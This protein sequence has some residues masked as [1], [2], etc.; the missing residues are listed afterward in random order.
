MSILADQMA[1]A[2]AADPGAFRTPC[3][4]YNPDIIASAHAELRQAI[5]TPLIVSLKANPNVDLIMR[6]KRVIDEAGVEVASFRELNIVAARGDSPCYVNNPSLPLRLMQASIGAGARLVLDNPGQVDMLLGIRAPRPVEPVML[7]ANASVLS[8]LAPG[9]P[10]VRPDQF[11]M[12]WDVLLSQAERLRDSPIRVAG[13]HVFAGSNSFR[14]QSATTAAA[15]PVM[16]EALEER[17]GYKL[18][19]INLGGGFSHRWREEDLDFAGYRSALRRLPDHVA[20]VHEAGRAVFTPGGAFMARVVARKEIGERRY[21][22]CDGGI[23]QNFLLCG[24]E[25]RFR[26]RTAAR[27]L[28]AGAAGSAAGGLVVGSSCSQDDIIGEIPPGAGDPEVGELVAFPDCGAYHATYPNQ[29]FLGLDRA[30]AYLL[31]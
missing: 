8:A 24:T 3:F 20:V 21:F 19:M 9:G 13:F 16:V 12:D 1:A 4:V 2:V 29:G 28:N 22:V 31:P 17:L 11:G 14:A 15:A 23:A 27:R 30:E 26:K 6:L 18:T 10:P 5:G 7:R 25:N